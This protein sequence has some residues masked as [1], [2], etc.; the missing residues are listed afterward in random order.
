M[1]AN[2]KNF[3]TDT[4]SEVLDKISETLSEF[5]GIFLNT[6]NLISVRI[7]RQRAIFQKKSD[8]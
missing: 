7:F 2:C 5:L 3:F 6:Y 4:L 8:Y 1:N